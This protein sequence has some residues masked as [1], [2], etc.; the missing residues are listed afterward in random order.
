M[1][2]KGVLTFEQIFR[3]RDNGH[4]YKQIGRVSD[5]PMTRQQLLP[6]LES[7][8]KVQSKTKIVKVL[9]AMA[10]WRE[11]EFQ[12]LVTGTVVSKFDNVT[13]VKEICSSFG[14]E[15]SIY[16]VDKFGNSISLI[17]SLYALEP[18]TG[19]PTLIKAR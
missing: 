16:E 3:F 18:G 12:E 8:G 6:A 7:P 19:I 4:R 14:I 2:R 5:V 17:S 1:S 10:T 9:L 11:K 15:S 13:S